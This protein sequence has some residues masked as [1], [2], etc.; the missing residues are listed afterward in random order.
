MFEVP[1]RT[2]LIEQAAASLRHSIER[3]EWAKGLPAERALSDLLQVSRPTLRE[4][5][6]LLH[7]EGWIRVLETD[8]RKI[9]VPRTTPAKPTR[10]KLVGFITSERFDDLTPSDM[11]HLYQLRRHLQDAGVRLEVVADAR[12]KKK[13][14]QRVLSEMTGRID[15][16]CWVLHHAT[17]GVQRWFADQQLPVI[18]MG[19]GHEGIRFPS[20]DWDHAAIGHHAATTFLSLGH[21]RI[22]I[23]NPQS[24]LAGD[25][26]R[27]QSFLKLIQSS[28]GTDA[29]AV[30]LRHDGSPEHI[31]RLVGA[32]LHSPSP[33]D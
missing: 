2:S 17:V 8:G 16:G 7:R 33:P 18:I 20:L 9:P 5:L 13:I 24:G 23:L 29:R 12:L 25:Q 11:S 14:L 19:S 6:R 27:E 15:A 22:A 28:R 21:R 26:S 30:S 31:R 32:A 4:A 10:A 3:G 1:K